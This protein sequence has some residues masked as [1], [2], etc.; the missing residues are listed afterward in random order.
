MITAS[1]T[2]REKSITRSEVHRVAK[3]RSVHDQVS[4][5]GVGSAVATEGL[6]HQGKRI[7]IA[8]CNAGL[9]G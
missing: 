7:L 4:R 2:W 9:A 3:K 1:T 8:I 5:S 6:R